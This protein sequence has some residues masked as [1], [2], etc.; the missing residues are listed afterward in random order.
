MDHPAGKTVFA[1]KIRLVAALIGIIARTHM[2][3]TA[4]EIARLTGRPVEDRQC[5][6][7][8]FGV[9]ACLLDEAVETDVPVD[10][11]FCCRL[12]HIAQD[13]WAVGN[14]LARRPRFEVITECVHV[15]V[16][17]DAR[18]AEEIPR[19]A[20]GLPALENGIGFVGAARL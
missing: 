15:A 10:A 2:E 12:A 9:P 4:G 20:N 18:I 1:R 19:P 13:G 7:G 16:R 8:R 17:P 14:R 11:V 5:P 3:H 6:D